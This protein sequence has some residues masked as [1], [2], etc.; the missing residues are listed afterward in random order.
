MLREKQIINFLS[1]NNFS[2]KSEDDIEIKFSAACDKLNVKN[3]AAILKNE[4]SFK[5]VLNLNEELTVILPDEYDELETI[6]R[7]VPN[8]Q[9]SLTVTLK[10]SNIITSHELIN[11]LIF[12]NMENLYNHLYSLNFFDFEKYVFS[13]KNKTRIILINES[14]T[15]NF[16]N[17]FIHISNLDNQ[18]FYSFNFK[19][20]DI[21]IL[22]QKEKFKKLSSGIFSTTTLVPEQLKFE[23]KS[24]IKSI[25]DKWCSLLC[26]AYLSYYSESS[27]KN[28]YTFYFQGQK[29]IQLNIEV[30]DSISNKELVDFYEW[31][32]TD[33]TEDKLKVFQNLLPSYTNN[34]DEIEDNQFFSLLPKIVI[35]TKEN[36]NFFIQDN[37]KL[38][39]EE[40]KKIEDMVNSTGQLISGEINKITDLL[41]RTL[42]GIFISILTS[43]L[44]V[45]LKVQFQNYISYALYLFS[46]II[47]ITF[48]Y[49]IIFSSINIRISNSLFNTRISEYEYLFDIDKLNSI[50][51]SIKSR[52][53]VFYASLIITT[54]IIL[55]ILVLLVSLG[56]Y[57][58]NQGNELIELL[59]DGI[60]KYTIKK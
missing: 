22:K 5:T 25:F 52:N 39:V 51:S 56:M 26:L 6:L 10:K 49:V 48:L 3:L 14:P 53:R 55:V 35:N 23:N 8:N 46:A 36:F 18:D 42:S 33:K 40:R 44:A 29:K 31:L 2:Y 16:Q 9:L 30:K 1:S 47:L 45:V 13:N 58:Q 43:L 11:T 28:F 54:L 34:N 32:Y 37:I 15:I 57:F 12:Y 27:E 41:I 20:L 17:D 4:F 59:R 24:S 21:E 60:D 7:L 38:F 19:N 50:K